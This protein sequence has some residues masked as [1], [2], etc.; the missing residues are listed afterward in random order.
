MDIRKWC[1]GVFTVG[2]PAREIRFFRCSVYQSFIA[3]ARPFSKA[4]SIGVH[5]CD[6]STERDISPKFP[7][8]VDGLGRTTSRL[9]PG[10][11]YP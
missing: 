5:S 2:F 6:S 11:G 8:L 3:H 10:V 1:I 7:A 4:I 9:S